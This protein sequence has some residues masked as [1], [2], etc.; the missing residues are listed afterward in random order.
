MMCLRTWTRQCTAWTVGGSSTSHPM[1]E[2]TGRPS[3]WEKRTSSRANGME[4]SSWSSQTR[5]LGSTSRSRTRPCA[6]NLTVS[7]ASCAPR[8]TAGTLAPRAL[9]RKCST[10]TP[11][12]AV[13]RCSVEGQRPRTHCRRRRAAG[14][15]MRSACAARLKQVAVCLL[16][17]PL[18]GPART[19]ARRQGLQAQALGRRSLAPASRTGH[20]APTKRS[21][22]APPSSCASARKWHPP[23]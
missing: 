4:T 3:W 20:W 18:D 15:Q 19:I 5:P 23:L 8:M 6:F 13:V 22:E 14:F 12:F 21:P 7:L 10:R 9:C 2:P 1:E 17:M 16:G 11:P